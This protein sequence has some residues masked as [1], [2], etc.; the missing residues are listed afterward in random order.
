[1]LRHLFLCALAF[2]ALVAAEPVAGPATEP[3]VSKVRLL[4]IGNSFSG[5]A[6]RY[7]PDLVSSA[8]C[9]LEVVHLMI[10]GS[11]L[12]V[13][14]K[15]AE[16][17]LRDPADPKGRYPKGSLPENFDK[18]PWDA[19]T[20]QQYSLI[21]NDAK[22]YH[23]FAEN[24]VELIRKRAPQ[25]HLYIHETWA[26]RFDD[27][28]FSA[29]GDLPDCE[30]MHA[31]IAAAYAG[32]AKSLDLTIIPSGDAFHLL[33]SDASWN[34]KID[35]LWNAKTAQF[36][37]LP[38]N[39]HSLHVGWKWTEAKKLEFDGHHASGLGQYLAGCVWFETL[40]HRTAVG[41]AFRPK[42]MTDE[43]A[44]R[45][46]DAAHRAVAALQVPAH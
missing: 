10:G 21:A 16:L 8:G 7:L 38:D 24:L 34:Y 39:T 40:F 30:T 1:M 28:R 14:W 33:T 5:N 43:I 45:L 35:P 31:Q 15:Q 3:A 25:A 37:A 12:E 46:Q 32:V 23:P 13:H 4:A 18:G 11:S 29:K 9:E 42:D 20:I 36:P 44:N 22:T 26:Y 41:N 6:L 17:A 27:A 2:T 19:V